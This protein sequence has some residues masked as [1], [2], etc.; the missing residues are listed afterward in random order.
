MSTWRKEGGGG[1]RP[2]FVLVKNECCHMCAQVFISPSKPCPMHALS[3]EMRYSPQNWAR[4][5]TMPHIW[6]VSPKVAQIYSL[7]Y[8]KWPYATFAPFV[9]FILCSSREDEN[10]DLA[11]YT[12]GT[13]GWMDPIGN[14]HRPNSDELHSLAS[15]ECCITSAGVS[16]ER[17]I[18]A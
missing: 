1:R 4:F 6:K 7:R 8:Q 15:Q 16:S 2:T 11:T 12:R 17:R 18:A 13:D 14:T 5:P 10:Y 9:H 3:R